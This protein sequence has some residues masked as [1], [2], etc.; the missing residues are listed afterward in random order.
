[1][2]SSL[3]P[4]PTKDALEAIL[5]FIYAPLIGPYSSYSAYPVCEMESPAYLVAAEPRK[6]QKRGAAMAVACQ[7]AGGRVPDPARRGAGEWRL[8][9][10]AGGQAWSWGSRISRVGRIWLWTAGLAMMPALQVHVLLLC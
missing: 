6:R 5:H 8:A 1:M 2:Q 9:A 7:H 10:V 3:E 4:F